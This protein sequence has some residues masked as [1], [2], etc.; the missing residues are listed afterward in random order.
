MCRD[1][2]FW[3]PDADTFRPE[4]WE[5]TRPGWEYTPFGGG[6]RTCPGMRLV[7]VES[8]Y[9]LAMLARGFERVERR[10][11]EI[12]WREEW[13]LTVQSR[14]GCVVGLVPARG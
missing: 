3:G 1:E 10:D 7:F 8:A 11:D 9:V 12:E 6:P 13:R 5:T 4:R 2:S 14:N